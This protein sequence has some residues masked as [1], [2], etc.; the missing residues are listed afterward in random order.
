MVLFSNPKAC[1]I[2]S[3]GELSEENELIEIEVNGKGSL[4]RNKYISQASSILSSYCLKG[5]LCIFLFVLF[6]FSEL[7]FYGK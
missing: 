4:L 1:Q 5:D 7:P 2:F 3:S 6:S